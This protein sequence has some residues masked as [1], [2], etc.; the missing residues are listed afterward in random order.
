MHLHC[1]VSVTSSML[2]SKNPVSLMNAKES[3]LCLFRCSFLMCH[4]FWFKADLRLWETWPSS[5]IPPHFWDKILH[6][7]EQ[8][9]SVSSV[10][11][12][13]AKAHKL[14]SHT[15][16]AC[17]MQF[18]SQ[19]VEWEFLFCVFSDRWVIQTGEFFSAVSLIKISLKLLWSHGDWSWLPCLSGWGLALAIRI[20]DLWRSKNLW[21]VLWSSE[22]FHSNSHCGA[23]FI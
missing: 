14:V 21:R 11:D 8:N 20:I 9:K 22:C 13:I 4:S 2:N 23:G 18:H 15:V 3:L 5:W 12:Y 1:R 16:C 17:S 6:I 7:L 19:L 10:P